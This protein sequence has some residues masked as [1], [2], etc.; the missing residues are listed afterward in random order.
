MFASTDATADQF[1]LYVLDRARAVLRAQSYSEHTEQVYLH[2]I[3]QFLEFNE[4]TGPE[5]LRRCEVESFLGTLSGL[6][7]STYR[8]ARSALQFLRTDVLEGWML[9]EGGGAEMSLQPLFTRPVREEA[10]VRHDPSG[11]RAT[12]AFR[13]GTAS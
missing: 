1:K 12:S 6:K 2:W 7:S 8:Q 9:V 10:S 4:A 11:S 13:R 5:E 3:R